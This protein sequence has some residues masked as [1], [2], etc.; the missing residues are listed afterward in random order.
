MLMLSIERLAQS[1]QDGQAQAAEAGGAPAQDWWVGLRGVALERAP[2]VALAILA[3]VA[4][5]IGVR[6]AVRLADRALGRTRVDRTLARFLTNMLRMGLLTLL[7]LMALQ[8]VGIETTSFV[9]I[10]GAAGFAVGFA[11]KD[12]LGNFAAGVLI[13]I[14]RPFKVGDVIEAAGTSGQV[15]EVGVV[16][17]VIRT[18]DNRQV[19]VSNTAITSGNIVNASAYPTRRVDMVFGISYADDID[20]A[21]ALLLEILALD[22]RVLK[23]PAPVVAVN[24]LAESSVNLICRP[25][26]ASGDYWNVYWDTCAE[27]KRRFDAEGITIPYPQRDVHLHQ[28]GGREAS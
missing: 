10:L 1:A 16:S 21:R 23:D 11:L 5:W 24:E 13:M 15:E 9:A 27:V 8:M 3:L 18:G 17:T 7:V 12:S 4:G 19:I 22:P 20:R 2:D 14:F 28:I 25:W 26:T 6:I